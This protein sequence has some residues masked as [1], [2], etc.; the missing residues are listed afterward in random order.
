MSRRQR[1]RLPD[2][3]EPRLDGIRGA[4]DRQ[5]E[6]DLDLLDPQQEAQ[7]LRRRGEV[8]TKVGAMRS[9]LGRHVRVEELD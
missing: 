6:D 7:F 2:E 1:R 8:R 4:V 5:I 3:Y 9:I